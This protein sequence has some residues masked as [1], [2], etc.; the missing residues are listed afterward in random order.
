MRGNQRRPPL[1]ALLRESASKAIPQ[2]ASTPNGAAIDIFEG[3]GT[4]MII[5]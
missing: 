3:H 5:P 2:G 4:E 1:G